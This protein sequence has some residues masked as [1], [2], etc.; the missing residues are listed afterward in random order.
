MEEQGTIQP[1]EKKDEALKSR[2]VAAPRDFFIGPVF[3][4]TRQ[5]EGREVLVGE[6]AY[7]IG[8][9]HPVDPE[10]KP[11][12]LD[13]RHARALA[14]IISF[15]NRFSEDR[16]I[17]FS[18]NEFCNRYAR[19]N[20]GRYAR[21]IKKILGDLMDTYFRI[22]NITTKERHTYRIIERFHMIEKEIRRKDDLRANSN[23]QEM[24]FDSITLSPEFYEILERIEELQHI[25]LEVF[26]SIRS[27]LAQAIYLYIPSRAHHH[28]EENP[29][30]I[31]LT[32]LLNQV[33]HPVPPQ[34]SKRQQLFIQN[35]NSIIYQLDGKETLSGFFHVRLAET[36]DGTDWKLQCWVERECHQR[37]KLPLPPYRNSKMVKAFLASGRAGDEL[38]KRLSNVLPLDDYDQELMSR[39]KIKI[40]GNEKAFELAKALL[41]KTRFV[42]LLSEAKGDA[43][44]G[45]PTTKSPNHR[46]MNRIME[47]L[48][49]S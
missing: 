36:S 22:R 11:P 40:E 9:F 17:R 25:K 21:D 14:V 20:G 10:K 35:K 47:A 19:S 42:S 1:A 28:T 8:G 39:A 18:L 41:G 31:T 48:R 3:A 37:P 26:T 23:Q 45:K 2:L 44:E 34:K 33:S 49:S 15:R 4:A 27:P 30:E 29:F 5:T 16:V 46:L 24:W 43:L 38:N 32:T 12:A 13:V 7:T 6:R